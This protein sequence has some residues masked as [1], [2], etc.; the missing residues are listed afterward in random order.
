[1]PFR[2]I[3]VRGLPSENLMWLKSKSTAFLKRFKASDMQIR[4]IRDIPLPETITPIKPHFISQ[5]EIEMGVNRAFNPDTFRVAYAPP[6]R[7][8]GGGGNGRT[9]NPA[10]EIRLDDAVVEGIQEQEEVEGGTRY[11]QEDLRDLELKYSR[12]FFVKDGS[13]FFLYSFNYV[14]GRVVASIYTPSI[15][16]LTDQRVIPFD[17]SFD[18]TLPKLGYVNTDKYSIFLLRNH[19][20]SSSSK[21]RKGL[22]TDIIRSTISS[23]RE[24]VSTSLPYPHSPN[25]MDNEYI[26]YS[27]ASSIF[28]RVYPTYEEALQEVL[29]FNRLSCA[30]ST[31]YCIKLDSML[32]KFVLLKNGWLIASW[33]NK[34]ASWSIINPEF[35][36]ELSSLNIPFYEDNQ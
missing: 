26:I 6:I 17:D 1:M 23:D 16:G 21:Y 20:R 2:H 19:K 27:L 5:A 11:T 14:S 12:C 31:T 10:A 30:F 28:N 7:A 9:F 25:R 29:S 3:D 35:N 33:D 18:F 4:F 24:L 32:N 34:K 13:I 15:N 36:I 22:T 8:G